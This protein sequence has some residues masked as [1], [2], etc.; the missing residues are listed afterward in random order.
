MA[1]GYKDF[2]AGT[3][4]AAADL[5]DYCE[6]QSVMRFADATARD[7][8]LSAVKTE[9]MCAYVLDT[10]SLTVY[11]GTTW[12]T[13][14]P[15]HGGWLTY[16]PTFTGF[17][18]GS[19]TTVAEYCRVGRLVF[20]K[21][22]VTLNASTV[23]TPVTIS[24]PV[25]GTE[26]LSFSCAYTDASAGFDYIGVAKMTSTTVVTLKAIDTAHLS[27]YAKDVDVTATVP[28]TWANSDV[29]RIAGFYEAAADA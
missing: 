9:G 10:N 20:F 25:T 13:V 23:S 29:W 28:V 8:A 18:A 6:L 12:S 21:V 14:G 24:L 2:V 17:T 22:Q 5:E 26:L 16:T 15:V 27:G 1:A 7:T 11:S 3:V 4:L 19:A